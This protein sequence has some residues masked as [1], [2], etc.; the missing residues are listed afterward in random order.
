MASKI[1]VI[2]D[3]RPTLKMFKL[4]LDV[5]G[6]EVFTAENGTD[7]L[8]LFE[9][10]RMPIVLTDIK[11]PGMN[12]LEVLQRIKQIAPNTEVIIITGHGD[13]DLAIEALSLDATDFINKP[14]NQSNL[15][16]ALKRAQERIRLSQ[17]DDEEY[18]VRIEGDVSVIEIAG[19][20][21]SGSEKSLSEA[22]ATALKNNTKLVLALSDNASVNGAGIALMT[23][24]LLKCRKDGVSVSLVGL[25][26][27]MTSVFDMV[28]ISKIASVYDTLED[29]LDNF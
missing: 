20:I 13:M 26:E 23:Q 18:I 12:G 21:N 4:F 1:L 2:D 8:D 19:A 29:A 10:H 14:I 22:V 3:E 25:A 5:Y 24:S 7:G 17:T 28:G 9:E 16:S 27:N 11:M 15:E 6:Y